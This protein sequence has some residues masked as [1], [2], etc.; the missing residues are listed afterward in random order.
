MNKLKAKHV[1]V[2]G[3]SGQIAYQLLFRIASGELLGA[4]QPIILHIL[5]IPAAMKALEGVKMELN[6]CAFPLL[7]KI[8]IS[9]DPFEAFKDVDYAL[10]V[11]AKPRGPG[12]ERGDLLKDN[13]MIFVEQGKALNAVANQE[14]KVFVVGNPCNTNCLIAM[15]HAPRLNRRHFYA[16]TRLDQNRASFLLAEKAGVHSSD[17]SRVAIW[18]NHSS[19]QVPDFIHAYIKGQPLSNSIHDK[20]WLENDFINTVRNRGA[21]IIQARGK[22]SAASAAHALIEAVRDTL[23]PTRE[24]DWFSSGI[25]SDG[26]NYGIEDDLIF[27]FP[28]RTH[29]NETVNI[30]KGLDM[31]EFLDIRLQASMK[32]LI[33]ERDVV[34]SLI[35]C[36]V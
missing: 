24:N 22:S 1:A 15:S 7:E 19:T 4:K 5:E 13:G 3:G 8:E 28:L 27:S 26:N 11:G 33:E 2:T 25:I 31:H 18:G 35:N 21:A 6:D 30:V 32:E 23:T 16:M 14:A 12:M 36:L 9:S 17:L 20:H 10:L 34:K 29:E